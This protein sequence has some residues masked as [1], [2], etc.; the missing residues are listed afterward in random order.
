MARRAFHR[1]PNPD[2]SRPASQGI[3]VAVGELV[4]VDVGAGGCALVADAPGVAAGVAVCVLSRMTCTTLVLVAGEVAGEG[5]ATFVGL[6]GAAVGEAVGEISGVLARAMPPG[7]DDDWAVAVGVPRPPPPPKPPNSSMPAVTSTT[8][9]AAI[10]IA[11]QRDVGCAGGGAAMVPPDAP[12][13]VASSTPRT[14][15]AAPCRA[16]PPAAAARSC[17]ITV[18]QSALRPRI[19]S[20]IDG[21][22]VAGRSSFSKNASAPA[23][24]AAC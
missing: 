8:A 2:V 3:G 24:S 21:R 10:P 13:A 17:Q 14:W 4:G 7:V 18:D 12:V 5:T 22:S 11:S 16:A 15:S 9:A 19:T 20:M 1:R 23:A 6:P